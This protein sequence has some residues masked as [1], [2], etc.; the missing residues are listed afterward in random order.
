MKFQH[1]KG[2]IYTYIGEG[3]HTETLEE[4]VVYQNES[5]NIWLRPKDMFF[6]FVETEHGAKPRFKKIELH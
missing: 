2:G 5:G 1:Y 6:G 3:V 4:Y